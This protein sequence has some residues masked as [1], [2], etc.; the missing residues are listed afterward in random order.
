M[1]LFYAPGV[2]SNANI[3]KAKKNTRHDEGGAE[4][5]LLILVEE[6]VDVAVEDQAA[7]G[8][9]G[10]DVLRPHLLRVYGLG[11]PYNGSY[12]C[13]ISEEVRKKGRDDHIVYICKQ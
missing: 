8:L 12:G 5:E 6:V 4:G 11:C 9:Q 3:N 2:P 1:S 13:V 7:H 10:E